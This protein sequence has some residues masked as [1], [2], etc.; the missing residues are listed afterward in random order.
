[1]TKE[2][3]P[4]RPAPITSVKNRVTFERDT[5]VRST[6]KTL[7]G[8]RE[9]LIAAF[10]SDALSL[11][12]ALKTH[13]DKKLPNDTFEEQRAFRRA[14]H[15]LSNLI[16]IEVMHHKLTV[17]KAPSIGW[18]K[19]L[20]PEMDNFLLPFPQVQWLNSAWQWYANGIVIPVLRNKLHPFYG[21]YFPTR[22]DHLILFD[23]WLKRY[24]GS[25]K[26]AIDVGI[27]SGIL[28][29]QMV[30]YGFQKVYGTDTN[31]NAI[32]GVAETMGESKLSRKIDI[33]HASYFG[34]YKKQTELI[35]FNPPWLPSS[36]VLEGIDAAM[37]Y[38][39]DLL[40]VFFEKA[41]ERLLPDGQLVVLFSNLARITNLTK[42]HPIEVELAQHDRF[43]L[44]RC[45]KKRV[46]MASKDTKRD[47][48]WRGSEEVELWVLKHKNTVLDF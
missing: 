31:P 47:Q 38:D 26:T 17:K 10:Y 5:D 37:Y 4:N 33:E 16:V 30:K 23:N 9:V 21:T 8:G 35:V 32:I 24:E 2:I 48:H 45:F 15:K 41:K 12:K 18:F 13:L 14:Y 11:L 39:K 20:Y 34:A 28:S 43:Q 46:R 7:E 3:Q 42:E 27:G 1:M 25:K 29:F 44:E 36:S 6:I 22:F 19:K 40:P